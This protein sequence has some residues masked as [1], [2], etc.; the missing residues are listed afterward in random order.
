MGRLLGEVSRSR[1]WGIVL[2]NKFPKNIY[3]LDTTL[4]DG[5][6]A[7][8]VSL[9]PD[10]K[11]RIAKRLDSLG[12]D[13][14]EAGFAA[15]SEGEMEAIRRISE[16]GLRAQIA[17]CSRGL[18]KDIDAVTES[19]ADYIH[20]VIPT[21]DIH[22]RY[23]LKKSREEILKITKESV[24]YAKDLGLTVELSAE[25]ATR[26]ELD[27][28][29][30]V[31]ETGASVGVDKVCPCDTVGI[32]T[33]ERIFEFYSKLREELPDIP[34]SVHCHNDLG[35][36]TANSLAALRAGAEEVHVTVNGL[37][38]RAGNAA[39]EEVATALKVLYKTETSIKTELLYETSKFVS[40][41][42]GV[43]IQPN[44]A[45]VGENAF[46]H[47]A[48][49]HTHGVLQEPLTYEAFKPELV[50]FRRRIMVGKHA[51]LHGLKALISEIG[52]KPTDEQLKEIFNR[53]KRVGDK[54]KIVTDADLLKIVETV[55]NLPKV[56]P[57]KLE[58]ITVVTGN[59]VTPT[60]SVRL[61]LDNRELTEA[62]TG[63]GPVDAAI[64]AIRKAVA[65]VEPISLEQYNVKAI[66]GGSDAVVEVNVRLRRGERAATA[67]SAN[68]DIVLASVEAMLSGMAVLLSSYNQTTKKSSKKIFK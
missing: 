20:L 60:A 40:K 62:S 32:M 48:G 1:K 39:L 14:I 65:A 28:L 11:L 4:R 47:E 45:I 66:T 42:T 51:G 37:G 63:T 46:A 33:P 25:D 9:T 52:L 5:E 21:S 50:G 49:I 22:L 34:I 56:R 26:T 19:G 54:G 35:M 15:V 12:V 36:A 7:P 59:R 44:K 18:K 67:M 31:F 58:E 38:E 64:N 68:E 8:G 43:P 29:I 61:K 30:E 3:F 27:Y 13:V 23:K 16:A 2:F 41:L 57:I 55:M 53:V 17:S 10:D 6:Q 24:K